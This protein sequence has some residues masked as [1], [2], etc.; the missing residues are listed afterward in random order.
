MLIQRIEDKHMN[1]DE[2]LRSDVEQELRWEPSIRAERIGV[3][4]TDG[5]IELDGHVDS[6]FE[7]WAAE[8]AA[9]RVQN[10]KAIASEIKV[11]MP[12]VD[13]RSDSDV[14]RAA[15]N[16][17]EWNYSVPATVKVQVTDGCV[18]LTGTAEWQYQKEEAGRAVRSLRG[19]KWV[20]NDIAVT[21]AVSA[22]GV[23]AK[24]EH[25]L[26]RSAETDARQIVVETSG[27]KVT[28]RGSVASWSERLEAQNAAWAAPGVAD[29][30]DLIT[31]L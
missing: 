16:H 25:A 27:S 1:N 26:K 2:Q 12:S 24:I 7:K 13:V 19:V 17:L 15:M 6:Y 22:V 8:T 11:E 21:P 9:M 20:A 28:L 10:A 3:S 29:V 30:E 18:T 4:V 23:K 5:V 14:A 31:V